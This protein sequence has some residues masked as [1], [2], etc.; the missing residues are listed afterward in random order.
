MIQMKS[1]L[2]VADNSGAK[3]VM[4]IKP[5]KASWVDQAAVG[6]MMVVSVKSAE[7]KGR[8]KKGEVLKAVLVRTK[9]QIMRSDG[10]VIKFDKNSVVLLND[11]LEPIGT[12]VFGP[13]ARE[14]RNK[15][16]MKIISLAEEVI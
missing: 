7:P 13:V 14:L 1:K 6:D 3:V 2:E 5:I 11:K 16:F 8:V 15:S 9:K 4:C 12:R 10:S